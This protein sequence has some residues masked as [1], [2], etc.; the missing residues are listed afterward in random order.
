MINL[1]ILAFTTVYEIL[2]TD[3]N[4]TNYNYNFSCNNTIGLTIGNI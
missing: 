4:N 2:L 1:K 3:K